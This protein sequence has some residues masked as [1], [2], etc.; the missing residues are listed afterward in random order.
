[1]NNNKPKF[2]RFNILNIFGYVVGGFA[3]SCI[4]YVIEYLPETKDS[5]K[6]RIR[7]AII[8]GIYINEYR[9]LINGNYKHVIRCVV[10]DKPLESNVPDTPPKDV[11]VYLKIRKA[12]YDRYG[13]KSFKTWQEFLETDTAKALCKESLALKN[14]S[15]NNVKITNDNNN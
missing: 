1:M 3:V 14:V 15:I 6:H 13:S 9:E 8:G 12:F 5:W 10:C 4:P 7:H 11:S 2:P